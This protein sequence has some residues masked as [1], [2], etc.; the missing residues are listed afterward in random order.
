ML[1]TRADDRETVFPL[2]RTADRPGLPAF[3]AGAV[4]RLLGL[5][6]MGLEYL[7]LPDLDNPSRFLEEVFDRLDVDIEVSESDL[8]RVPR[9]GP[10]IVVANHPFGGIDGCRSYSANTSRPAA[11]CSGSTSTRTSPTSSTC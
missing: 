4:E 3:I 5:E 1:K 8:L 6:Y 7:K 11:D 9:K 10:T 2:R